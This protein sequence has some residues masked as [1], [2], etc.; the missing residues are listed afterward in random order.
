[1]QNRVDNIAAGSKHCGQW[2]SG[3]S[4]FYYAT[5]ESRGR[6][7]CSALDVQARR[8]AAKTKQA[9]LAI[10][11]EKEFIERSW[12]LRVLLYTSLFAPWDAKMTLVEK[13]CS[14]LL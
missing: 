9:G 3:H 4:E 2:S 12:F 6:K 1:M 13:D 7:N 10:S 11:M 14:D 5:S 8:F